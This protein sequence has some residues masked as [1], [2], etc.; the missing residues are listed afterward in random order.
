M[1]L[2]GHQGTNPTCEPGTG[3]EHHHENSIY[4]QRKVVPVSHIKISGSDLSLSTYVEAV[5]SVHTKT[6]SNTKVG[7][8]Y[9]FFSRWGAAREEDTVDLPLNQN[10]M[11][12]FVF[13][14]VSV[15]RKRPL[16]AS[17]LKLTLCSS[18]SLTCF[19]R[20]TPETRLFKSIVYSF[21]NEGWR[22]GGGGGVS[23]SIQT[24][25]QCYRLFK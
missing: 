1:A 12:H 17:L 24:K 13:A 3:I 25:R 16:T 4:S 15:Q 23:K 18:L 14:S 6:N 10:S 19:Y 7:K 5:R 22:G 2:M 20:P 8:R 11:E 9:L 21:G